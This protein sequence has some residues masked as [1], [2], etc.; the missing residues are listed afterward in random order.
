MPLR[1]DFSLVLALAFGF[2]SVACQQKQPPVYAS[3][4]NQGTYALGFGDSMTGVRTEIAT[5]EAQL[6]TAKGEFAKYPDQLTKPNWQDV[7]SLY[8]AADEDGKSSGYGAEVERSEVVA[9]FYV[10]EKDELNKK[11]AG[12]AQYAVKQKECDVEVYGPTSYALGK[13]FEERLRERLRDRSEAHRY[14]DEHE[15]QLGKKNRPKLE[16]QI[17]AIARASYL[18]NVSMPRLRDHLKDG[19]SETSTVSKTLDR[20]A[21]EAHRQANDPNLPAAERSKAA[22]REQSALNSKKK[23]EPEVAESKRLSDE[24]EQRASDAKKSYDDAFDELE[25]AVD[26]KADSGA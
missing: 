1:P 22:A 24:M 16:D 14:L 5:V 13:A 23:L 12:A 21:D 3:S 6:Q 11:V 18:A 15:T 9:R 10:D 26:R 20:L 7:T 4:A 2:G 8:S 17:D 25:K 19:V